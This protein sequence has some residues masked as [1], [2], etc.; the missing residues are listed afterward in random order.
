MPRVLGAA[1]CPSGMELGGTGY[2]LGVGVC[3][4]VHYVQALAPDVMVGRGPWAFRSRLGPEGRTL[5]DGV[6]ALIKDTP[7]NTLVPSTR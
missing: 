6:G 1:L 5:V 2:C 4:G 3:L 7:Q